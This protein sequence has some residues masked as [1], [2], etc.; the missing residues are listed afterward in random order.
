M[1]TLPTR[2]RAGQ[3]MT[4]RLKVF[5]RNQQPPHKTNLRALQTGGLT[6]E[7]R[8]PGGLSARTLNR[9]VLLAWVLSFQPQVQARIKL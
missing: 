6:C 8:G 2:Q 3:E 4:L 1:Q 9:V 5:F 7:I